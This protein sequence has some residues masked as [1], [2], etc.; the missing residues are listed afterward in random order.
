MHRQAVLDLPESSKDTE[1]EIGKTSGLVKDSAKGT[2]YSEKVTL[3]DAPEEGKNKLGEFYVL[4]QINKTYIVAEN[5]DGLVI[6]DQHAAQERVNYEKFTCELKS[7]AIKTQKLL[8]PRVIE[9]DPI[10]HLVSRN[11]KEFLLGLGF[12]FEDFGQNSVKLI[13]IP[14]V[15]G[16]LKSTLFI[17]VINE[18]AKSK[19]IDSEIEERIIRFACR[20]SVKAGDELTSVQMKELLKDLGNCENPYSCPHGRPT[21]ISLS[22][23]DLERRFKRTGW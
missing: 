20:A 13:S 1:Y 17:D 21:I 8:S 10:R 12:E 3:T 14:Q 18:L 22:V 2:F 23:A 4:G 15:F 6:I 9:L 19:I 11:N 7:K 5:Q 16:R